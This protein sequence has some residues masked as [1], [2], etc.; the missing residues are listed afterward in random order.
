MLAQSPSAR[1]SVA[2]V[3]EQP[4][5]KKYIYNFVKD[6]AERGAAVSAVP[7][8]SA[9]GAGVGG[10]TMAFRAGAMKAAGVD[11]GG[12]QQSAF[13]GAVA[14]GLGPHAQSLNAQLVS[15]GLQSV[16]AK[17]LADAAAPQT[18]TALKPAFSLADFAPAAGAAPLAPAPAAAPASGA[19]LRPPIAPP[20]AHAPQAAPPPHLFSAAELQA[21]GAP[22]GG[23]G[24]S[25]GEAPSRPQ[26][27]AP[28]AAP[29]VRALTPT[30]ARKYLREQ[31]AACVVSNVALDLARALPFIHSPVFS[32]SLLNFF[33]FSHA[34]IRT[35]TGARRGA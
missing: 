11:G 14:A 23:G 27:A 26:A 6:A 8:G 19:A 3:L 1:P 5:L 31:R 29:E 17:A 35:Q 16:I 4:Y 24:G 9:A 25:A 7:A 10:L 13:A 21:R 2:E 12:A 32:L 34:L 20:R 18:A 15:L 28:S 33:T 30:R 22:A